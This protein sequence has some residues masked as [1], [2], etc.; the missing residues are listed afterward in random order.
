MLFNSLVNIHKFNEHITKLQKQ[1]TY[2][3]S[4][5]S[6][7]VLESVLPAPFFSFFFFSFFFVHVSLV[8]DN[9]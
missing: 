3:E 9:F 7:V 5:R 6:L 8:F 1:T 2:S 4:W